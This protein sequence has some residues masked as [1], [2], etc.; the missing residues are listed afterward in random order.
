MA[1]DDD[2]PTPGRSEFSAEEEK[3]MRDAR[4]AS[5]ANGATTAGILTSRNLKT[6]EQTVQPM[7]FRPIPRSQF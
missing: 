2:A 3:A 6:G 5:N 7:G 4:A 1:D